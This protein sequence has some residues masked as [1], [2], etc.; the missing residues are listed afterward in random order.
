[1]QG[2]ICSRCCRVIRDSNGTGCPCQ[3]GLCLCVGSNSDVESCPY[4]VPA[5]VVN[6]GNCWNAEALPL[7]CRSNWETRWRKSLL[8]GLPITRAT[9]LQGEQN[10]LPDTLPLPLQEGKKAV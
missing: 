9:N 4:H 3:D 7:C 10:L 8:T 1:M 2:V 6:L 5:T